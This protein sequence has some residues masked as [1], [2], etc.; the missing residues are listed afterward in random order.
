MPRPIRSALLALAALA[1]TAA[2][3]QFYN[4]AQ[5]DYGKNRV[6]YQD[7]LWQYYRFERLET[8]FYKGGRDLARYVALSGHKHLKDLERLLDIALDDRVQFI[9]YNSQSDFRQSNIGITGDEL[10]NVGG[11]TRIVG[12]KV[13]VYFEGDHAL[14]DRQVRSGLAQVML[15]Q[16]MYGGNWREVLKNSTLMNLPE[17]FTKGLVAHVSG[18]MDGVRSSRLRDA[19]LA[20]RYDRFNRLEGEDA[21]LMGQA[22]WNYVA[23]VYGQGVIPNILYMTRVSRNVESGFV[24]VL[25][26]PLKDLAADCLAHYRDRFTKEDQLR[27]ASVLEEIPLRHRK[28]STLSQFKLS[29]NGRYAAWVTNELGQYK[30]FV[31]DLS[32]Q[33]TWRIAK[34]GKRIDRIVDRSYPVL[35]WH[36]GSRA[37]SYAAERKG[38][39]YLR[40]YTLDDRKT[41]ERPV[42]MLEKLLSMAYAPDGRTMV[43]SGVREGRTDLYLHH[44]VGNR[45]EQLTNDQFDDLEP[46]FTLDGRGIL[47]SSDR[48]DDTLRSQPANAEVAL[49]NGHKDIFLYD[50]ASR[51]TLVRRLTSTSY[52]DESA[53][54]PLDSTAFTYLGDGSGLR[55]RYR[56]RYDSVVSHVDTTIHYR[57]F[58]VNDRLSRG[59]RS[60]LEHDVHARSGRLAEL[61]FEN[62]RYH[63]RMGRTVAAAAGGGEEEGATGEGPE[64]RTPL[65]D[66]GDPLDQVVKVAPRVPRPTGD[67][68][69]VENYQ[70]SD[71]SAPPPA[72]PLEALPP[73]VAN[74][75]APTA[76]G[77][78]LAERPLQFPEQRNYHVN[79]ATDAVLTQV[80]NSYN[81]AFYQPFTGAGNLNPGLSGM[82]QMGISDLFEDHKLVGGLRLALD[83]N[84]NDYFLTYINLKRRL[85]KRFTVQRR[86]MQGVS[87]AG[88]VKVLTHLA[89]YQV[90]W[91]FSEL[92]SVRASLLYRHDRYVLQS[93][94][95]LSLQ[96]PNFNDQ[97]VGGKL[98]YV[99]DSSVPRGLNL[100]TGWKFKVFGEYYVQPDEGRS[101]MQVLGLDA[102]HS[103]RIHR[104]LMLVNRL[105]GAT[106][107]GHRRIIH[108]LGGVDNWLF[109]RVD[110]SIPID[111]SQNY[112]YQSSATPMRGFYYN[113]RNGT[114]FGV[115]NTEVRWPIFRYLVNRPMRSDFLQNFQLVAFGDLGVAWTGPD[116]YSE[117]NTFNQQVVNSNPL[118][119]T[120]KNRR[121]PI[122]GGYGLGVRARLLGYFVRADWAWGVD[123]GRVLEPVFHL[124][125][126]LDI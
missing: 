104:D 24:Y 48:T 122:V 105:A 109:P 2:H 111:F 72:R 43:F 37:L 113:A 13:F 22:I 33:R 96:E 93:T 97:M 3:G 16:M 89:N 59:R 53:P 112:Y 65:S 45:Q 27:E 46:S 31:R 115:F 38:E 19:V 47:F 106:S 90:S 80:D 98:E 78:T 42:L 83:L 58:A 84:N 67:P 17:W 103:L 56:V 25:G 124:S 9:V 60:V 79:F 5:Q 34:A 119:I 117:E 63:L 123:D 52:A 10:Y 50:L 30:V 82:I 49:V 114:S 101:D 86:A 121:E 76:P 6:Q 108:F 94:D 99:F 40:T 51:S 8:Y 64:K 125:L 116:P 85:D 73:T 39:L 107:L 100:Y 88:V 12:T 28:R 15:D 21:V 61:V 26:V 18:P 81:A 14:L 95:L 87:R 11:V 118:L 110:N 55:D 71:E 7:F 92:A 66:L 77:D 32:E 68:V 4:G 1:V 120:I 36:P 35:A 57:Y 69:N 41:S 91:P 20:G 102:R 70:F 23:D 54:M 44:P 29:P 75:A 62:G 126:S 74:A